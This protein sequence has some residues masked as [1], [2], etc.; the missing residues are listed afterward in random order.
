MFGNNPLG[1]ILSGVVQKKFGDSVQDAAAKKLAMTFGQGNPVKNVLNAP[2]SFLNTL[3]NPMA[4]GQGILNSK[5][6]TPLANISDVK[7]IVTNP[8]NNKLGE[9]L[10]PL[11]MRNIKPSFGNTKPTNF[12]LMNNAYKANLQNRANTQQQITNSL[13]ANRNNQ[14]YFKE[15]NKG[16]YDDIDLDEILKNI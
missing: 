4:T 2:Q 14:G 11:L 7:N 5:I 8:D 10:Y 3:Q 13:A 16:I 12:A 1:K 15:Q 6:A 9:N